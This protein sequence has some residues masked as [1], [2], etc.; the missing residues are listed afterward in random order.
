MRP[1]C[2]VYVENYATLITCSYPG[3]EYLSIH[4]Y[5]INSFYLCLSPSLCPTLNNAQKYD[6]LQLVVNISVVLAITTKCTPVTIRNLIAR[7]TSEHL[8][9]LQSTGISVQS[10][11]PL[12]I[13]SRH[14]KHFRDT[15]DHTYSDYFLNLISHLTQNSSKKPLERWFSSYRYSM[16]CEAFW[17]YCRYHIHVEVFRKHK[18]SHSA[19]SAWSE[20]RKNLSPQI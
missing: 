12:T 19:R 4:V 18:S 8:F 3:T 17:N 15:Q 13:A 1:L 5:Y 14:F 2:A 7:F 16:S 11:C 9:S 6:V 20:V 10:C